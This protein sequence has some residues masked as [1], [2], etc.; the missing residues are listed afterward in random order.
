M[1][2]MQP[3]YKLEDKNNSTVIIPSVI[4]TIIICSDPDSNKK[5]KKEK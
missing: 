3:T 1:P 5:P 2:K 4:G